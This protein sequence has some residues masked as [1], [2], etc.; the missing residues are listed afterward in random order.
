M[1]TKEARALAAATIDSALEAGIDRILDKLANPDSEEG[2]KINSKVAE[3]LGNIRALV[4]AIKNIAEGSL[5]DTNAA[6]ASTAT[7]STIPIA[8]PTSDH[9]RSESSEHPPAKRLRIAGEKRP[10]ATLDL[11]QRL[12]RIE[13]RPETP[14]SFSK[15]SVRTVEASLGLRM[16]TFY[17]DLG[18]FQK[19]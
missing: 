10:Y 8:N 17:E 6:T 12:V 4:A 3:V 16:P 11:S 18:V 15:D 2:A 7:E 13:K 19:A 5:A 14:A 9:E 1:G